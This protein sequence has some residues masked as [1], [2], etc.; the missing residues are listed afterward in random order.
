M[1]DIYEVF[2]DIEITEEDFL[3]TEVNELEEQRI[4]KNLKETIRK[5]SSK[6]NNSKKRKRIAAVVCV[7]VAV[8]LGAILP[9]YAK[10][11][12][13][14]KDIF[15]ALNSP[16]YE[17][18]KENANEIN[19]TKESKNVKITINDAI[20]DG[21]N[22]SITYTV[23]SKKSLGNDIAL[24]S[25]IV[26]KENNNNDIAGA[27][28]F[29]KINDTTYVGKESFT[30]Y[31]YV[32]NPKENINFD[33]NI[34]RILMLDGNDEING[35]WNFSINLIATEG[36]VNDLNVST[37][38]GGVTVTLDKLT[39]NPM[40]AVINYSQSVSDTLKDKYDSITVSL[41]VSDDL[42]NVYNVEDKY[43]TG[44]SDLYLETSS[45]IEKIKSNASKLIITPK[46]LMKTYGTAEYTDQNVQDNNTGKNE[47]ISGEN[48]KCIDYKEI[49]LDPIVIDL[50]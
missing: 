30:I 1:K 9:S 18:Y 12:P 31:D 4:L 3:E 22:L 13:L 32:G 38:N 26:L 8:S 46:V 48:Y 17:N 39:I 10:D 11:I 33:L 7:A 5:E 6:K 15:K 16:I 36:K 37:E 20:F 35:K 28:S 41:E 14:V 2:N 45:V 50:K 25:N 40:S 29:T 34:K 47:T 27:S 42:G 49:D 24:A 44:N 43:S 19:V 23:E 21:T